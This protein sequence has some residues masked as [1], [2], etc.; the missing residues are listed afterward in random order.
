MSSGHD[1]KS[2]K[3][4]EHSS[5]PFRRSKTWQTDDRDHYSRRHQLTRFQY[6]KN[7]PE[8]QLARSSS[9]GWPRCSLR[10]HWGLC[11]KV[12]SKFLSLALSLAGTTCIASSWSRWTAGWLPSFRFLP[13]FCNNNKQFSLESIHSKFLFQMSNILNSYSTKSKFLLQIIF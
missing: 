9:H 6:W 10:K 5:G 4:F 11:S 1:M 12:W 13:G 2:C 8:V 3:C 7:N